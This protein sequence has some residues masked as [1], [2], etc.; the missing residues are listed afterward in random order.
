MATNKVLF[1]ENE[2]DIREM[3]CRMFEAVGVEAVC[4]AD[5]HAAMREMEWGNFRV[6]VLDLGMSPVDGL[7]CGGYLK[8]L[9][10]SLTLVA[11]T[12]YSEA[13][14]PADVLRRAG[15]SRCYRKGVDDVRFVR[16]VAELCGG[17]KSI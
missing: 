17:T 2:A 1:C 16:E 4:A 3:V 7:T 9:H 12:A 5:C 14:Q 13:V 15:F 11:Y 8:A 6:A 10:P